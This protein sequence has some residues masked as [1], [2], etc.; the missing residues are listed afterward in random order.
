MAANLKNNKHVE[1]LKKGFQ[2]IQTVAQEGNVK[3]FV[4]QF[5]AV[6]LVLLAFKFLGGKFTEKINNIN[7]QMDAIRMQQTNEREYDNNKRQLIRLEPRFPEVDGKNEY[8]VTQI[9]EIFKN[10]NL[11]PEVDSNQ[12]EDTSNPTYIAT[13]LGVSTE[14]NFNRFADFLAR[15]ENR[16]DFLKISEIGI[17]KDT[18][19]ENLGNNK[20]TL[21][22]NTI[23]PKEKIAKSLFKDYDKLV[24]EMQEEEA[25]ANKEGK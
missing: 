19:L 22:F 18:S 8:L 4:K 10:E 20:I 15:L 23:F 13:S 5:V 21:R 7:G 2:D 25:A 6:A 14:M 1:N 16:K 11:T 24:Q 12:N 17:E 3:L 9:L